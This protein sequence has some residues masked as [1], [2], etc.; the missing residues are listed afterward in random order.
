M[1]IELFCHL[2]AHSPTARAPAGAAAMAQLRSA[3]VL[4]AYVHS[5]PSSQLRREAQ[6]ALKVG[7]LDTARRLVEQ[8][9]GHASAP[10]GRAGQAQTGGGGGGLASA[11]PADLPKGPSKEFLQEQLRKARATEAERAAAVRLAHHVRERPPLSALD[12]H[13]E[14]LAAKD[15]AAEDEAAATAVVGRCRLT[16]G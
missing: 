12:S 8:S 11:A 9:T 5:I 16:P 4:E 2:I 15:A 14:E 1:Q 6:Q 7:D 13:L 10:I 3:K